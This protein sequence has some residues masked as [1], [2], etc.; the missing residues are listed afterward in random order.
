[1]PPLAQRTAPGARPRGG[2]VSQD[3][4]RLIVVGHEQQGPRTAWPNDPT[5]VAAIRRACPRSDDIE[6]PLPGP[7]SENAFFGGTSGEHLLQG[8]P[9]FAERARGMPVMGCYEAVRAGIRRR[10][11]G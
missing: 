3:R 4:I 8:E 9:V 7:A 1:M 10:P 11:Q 5:S 6:P 2:G